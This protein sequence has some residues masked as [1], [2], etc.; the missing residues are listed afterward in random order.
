MRVCPVKDACTVKIT[1]EGKTVVGINSE[2]CINC[3]QCI[4]ACTHNARDYVDDYEDFIEDMY[5]KKGQVS[6]LVDPSVKVAFKDVWQDVLRW[7]YTQGIRKIYD[8]SFGAEICTWA[9]LRA[10]STHTI[11]KVIAQPCT[12]VVNYIEK[13][14]PNLIS[15]LSPVHS[16]ADCMAIY[17]KNFLNDPA[18]FAYFGP[19]IAKKADF[20]DTGIIKYN[21]TFNRMKDYFEK[22]K[23]TFSSTGQGST[24][25]FSHKQGLMGSIY[26]QPG[27]MRDNLLD[28]KSGLNIAVCHGP[29]SAYDAL[30]NYDSQDETELADVFEIWG[31]HNGCNAGLGIG[32]GVTQASIAKVMDIT[33][34][35]AEKRSTALFIN[36]KEKLYKDFDKEL[37]L[38]TFMREYIPK[39]RFVPNPSESD[40]NNIYNSMCKTR[41]EDRNINCG[42][43]GYKTCKEMACS[44][45]RK[46]NIKENC[47]FYIKNLPQNESA[48]TAEIR[49]V[50][51]EIS[52]IL[53]Q[54]VPILTESVKSIRK[55]AVS[56]FT[57]NKKTAE[58]AQT[59]NSVISQMIEVCANP[60][61]IS[62]ETL[63]E[64]CSTL[65]LI[66]KILLNLEK[67]VTK[68]S[69]SGYSIDKSATSV[70][71]ITINI[72]ELLARVSKQNHTDIKK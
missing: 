8:V 35:D 23:I 44:I 40:L 12:A 3:G 25:E 41:P 9:H 26:S 28:Q 19:C 32:D 5:T 1:P 48:Q 31:C 70:E 11:D 29:H 42:A 58:A 20:E 72:N 69:E 51:Y 21:V 46:T 59:I 64:I 6:L 24:F 66:R 2:K 63:N 38:N 14:N 16:P 27:G 36:R 13:H 17:A 61:G 22:H 49:R 65:D 53:E 57:N 71:N 54:H 4:Q 30:I 45:Y 47:I 50:V 33:R 60:K 18:D 15:R 68:N 39:L 7:F 43:C 56:I 62:H 55:E 52:V 67:S 10:F 34:K 37:T